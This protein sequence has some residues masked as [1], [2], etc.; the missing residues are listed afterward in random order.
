MARAFR[1]AAI[2]VGAAALIVATAG[3]AA[4]TATAGALSAIGVSAS[5]ASVATIASATAAALS[6]ASTVATPKGTVGGNATKFKIDKDSGIP[7]AWGR[8]YVGGNVVHRQYY[9][10]PGSRMRNQRE[11]WVTVHSLGPVKSIGPLLIDKKPVSFSASGAA[12][13][14]FAGNMWLDTQLGLCPEAR[15]LRGPTGDFPGWNASSKLSGLAADLWTL[16]F[17]SKGKKFPTGLPQRGRVIEGVFVYDPRLDSTY[18]GGSGNCRI[19]DPSTHIYSENPWL[20]AITF[21]Y[22]FYQNGHLI[23]G[24]GLAIDGIDLN[25]F[26][27]AANTADMN[28]WKAGGVVYTT[29]DDDWDIMKML[30]HAGGG[31]VFAVGGQL[32]CTHAA[33]RVSIGTITSADIIGDIV[34]PS[35]ASIR[36]RRNTII[37]RIR[38]EE[39][40]WEVVPIAA[41]TVPEYAI[42]DRAPRPKETEYPLIQSTKQAAQIAMYEMLDARELEPIV[43]PCK[44]PAIGYRPGD[45]VTLEIPEANLIG[46]DVVLRE[47]ELDFGTFGV[48][49]KARSETASKHPYALGTSTTPPP[50]PDLSVP[51]LDL[52]PPIGWA[53]V[54]TMIP[55]GPGGVPMP[56]IVV[57]GQVDNPGADAVQFDYRPT[58]SGG[59]L[60]AGADAVDITRREITSVVSEASYEVSVRYSVRGVY[61]QRL[62]L[63]PVVIPKQVLTYDDGTPID[64]RKPAEPGADVTGNNKAKDTLNVNGRP[65]DE[66]VADLDL[67]LGNLLTEMLRNATFRGESDEIWYL[68]DGTPVR[69]VTQVLSALVDGHTAYIA[70]LRQVDGNGNLKAAFVLNS[71]GHVTGITQLNDG[72]KGSFYVVADEFGFVDPAGGTQA[73]PIKPL[74]YVDGKL[75]MD[76]VYIRKLDVDVVTMKNIAADQV[77]G[78]VSHGFPDQSITPGGGEVTIADL[79]GIV[80][81]DSKDG[82]GKVTIELDLDGTVANDAGIMLRAYVN[83]GSGYQLYRAKP[84]GIRVIDGNARWILPVSMSVSVF[85]GASVGV[86]FTAQSTGIGGGGL[87]ASYVRNVEVSI[88]AGYR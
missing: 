45:C 48:T 55:G 64:D 73:E 40:G 68:P 80:I 56:A 24:G 6:I 13:G 22:G 54:A 32:T 79:P 47:R 35:T 9:D 18:P 16:D 77:T 7:I 33:P 10:D 20:M 75:Y 28:G 43:L 59:W 37:P 81:G 49:F 71:K 51:G 65:A 38:L 46:R 4:P 34:A 31:E 15:A 5:A 29:S 61:G 78:L 82:K 30:A 12:L 57:S 72:T 62:V 63:G 84:Q 58:G 17:D 11:S 19:A 67:A 88:Q 25:P 3:A 52:D 8:T 1:T 76:N 87:N 50:T 14:D 74:Y 53:A 86:R 44:L 41:V 21:A 70:D 26:V 60:S 23:A 85:A 36:V 69:A 27:Q 39:Q 66:V 83:L 2:V 42:I